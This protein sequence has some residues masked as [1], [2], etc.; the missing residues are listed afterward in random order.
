M[1]EGKKEGHEE[2][3]PLSPWVTLD[4]LLNLTWSQFPHLW[5][6]SLHAYYVIETALNPKG[7]KDE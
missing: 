3:L 1:V 2:I 6:T 7:Y 4:K 5:R